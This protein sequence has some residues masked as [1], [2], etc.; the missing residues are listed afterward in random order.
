MLIDEDMYFSNNA[1]IR[2]ILNNEEI[3]LV[4]SEISTLNTNKLIYNG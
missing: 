3:S 2:K 1:E 4:N